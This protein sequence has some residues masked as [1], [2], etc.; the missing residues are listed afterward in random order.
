M[1]ILNSYSSSNEPIDASMGIYFSAL[2]LKHGMNINPLKIES[3]QPSTFFQNS[4][5]PDEMLLNANVA[6]H[7]GPHCLLRLNQFSEKVFMK[8]SS[9]TPQYIPQTI[10][11]IEH[12]FKWEISL[13]WKGFTYFFLSIFRTLCGTPNYIAPEV[14]GKKGHSFEVDVWSLGCIL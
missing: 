12:I 3:H 14:L 13:V 9:V 5:D 4:K 8:L 11:T 10:L 6:F 1:K 7:Q 2:R